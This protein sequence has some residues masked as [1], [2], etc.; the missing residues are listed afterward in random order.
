MT[1]ELELKWISNFWRRIGA[2]LIDTLLLGI[3]GYVIG[4][5]LESTFVQLGGWGRLVGFTIALIYFGIMNSSIT[6]GQTL[7]K[8][9]LKIRV[10]DNSNSTISIGKSTLRYVVLATPFSLNGAHFSNEAMLS[11]LIYPLSFIIFGGLFSIIYLYIFNRN[12][13]QS[14]H[15]LAVGSFVV[16]A[17][18]EKQE[19]EKVWNVHIVIVA[20]LFVVAAIVPAFTSQ[21]AQSEPFKEML[22]V[23]SALL[24]EPNVTYATITTNTTTFSSIKEDTKT[25]TYVSSQVFLGSNNVTDAEFARQLASIIIAKYPEATNKD[26]IQ[27]I[28]TYGYDIGI[29]SKWYSHTHNFD[30]SELKSGE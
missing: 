10:V 8:K 20:L 30:P 24:S 21:L 27:I 9:A 18:V 19:I 16:N 5:V 26:T 11:Y 6:G 2:L 23:Q 15:D 14:L 1:Q 13:R 12:T 29:S 25:T 4:L 3:F 22:S 17:D 7:G 28:L